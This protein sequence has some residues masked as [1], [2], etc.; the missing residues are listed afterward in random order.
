VVRLRVRQEGNAAIP[1]WCI[2]GLPALLRPRFP[3]PAACPEGSPHSRRAE[4]PASNRRDRE[5]ARSVSL[6][7]GD[8]EP[9][10]V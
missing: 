3:E 5:L 8:D 7:P 9:G 4:G 2:M 1:V 6:A 10:E